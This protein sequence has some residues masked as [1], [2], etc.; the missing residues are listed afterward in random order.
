MLPE[1]V[2]MVMP[3]DNVIADVELFQD[4]A[5]E[6]GSRFTVREGGKTVATG[7]VTEIVE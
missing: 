2:P 1:D 6:S 3:G 5:I 4:V 7:V